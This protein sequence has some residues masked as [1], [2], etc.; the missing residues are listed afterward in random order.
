MNLFILHW[1]NKIEKVDII[2][3]FQKKRL[4][5]REFFFLKKKNGDFEINLGFLKSEAYKKLSKWCI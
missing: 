4:K 1:S 5:R 3:T 2:A